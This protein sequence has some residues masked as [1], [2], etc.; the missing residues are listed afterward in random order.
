MFDSFYLQKF[1]YKVVLSRFNY[2]FIFIFLKSNI[3]LYICMEIFKVFS[4]EKQHF[5]RFKQDLCTEISRYLYLNSKFVYNTWKHIQ[6]QLYIT[7]RLPFF[8][9]CVFFLLQ[10]SFY[11][12]FFSVLFSSLFVKVSILTREGKLLYAFFIWKRLL[13]FNAEKVDECEWMPV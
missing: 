12:L 5:N 11:F 2:I 3:D 9:R 8:F 10:F 13:F 4:L 1:N 6:S 7:F